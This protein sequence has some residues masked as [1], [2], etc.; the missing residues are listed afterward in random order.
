MPE[1][2]EHFL[3]EEGSE[4]TADGRRD[5]GVTDRRLGDVDNSEGGGRNFFFF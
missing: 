4:V 1:S 2:S 5:G 3:I